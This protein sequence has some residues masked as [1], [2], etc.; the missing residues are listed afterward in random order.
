MEDIIK[1]WVSGT[2]EF[3]IMTSGTTGKP[4]KIKLSRN[5]LIWSAQATRNRLKLTPQKIACCLPVDKTSGFMQL[6]RALIWN[7][8]IHFFNPSQSPFKEKVEENF[9]LTSLTPSQFQ[10]LIIHTPEKLSLFQHILL[11]GGTLNRPLSYFHNLHLPSTQLWFTYGMTETA[12]HIA[13]QNLTLKEN[14]L[15]PLPDV[16]LNFSDTLEIYLPKLSLHVKTN[17]F[18]TPIQKGF[19]ILGRSDDVIN[20]GGIKIHPTEIEPLISEL[21]SS[22]NIPNLFYVAKA[23]NHQYGEVPILI[24]ENEIQQTHSHILSMIHKKLP[25]YH[26]PKTLKIV[27]KIYYTETGK[28]IRQAY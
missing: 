24:I 23:K 18:A 9:T 12:S 7:C 27:P 1:K 6:I 2:S 21:F 13:L 19:R 11:G 8:D 25:L 26:A 10:N 5:L 22:L 28:V 4:K 17:D 20:S 3:E 16:T 14:Y 15:T